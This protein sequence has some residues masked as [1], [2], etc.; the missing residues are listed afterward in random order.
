MKECKDEASPLGSM[1]VKMT[2]VSVQQHGLALGLTYSC[3]EVVSQ[4]GC[5]AAS[6]SVIHAGI[7][8]TGPSLMHCIWIWLSKLLLIIMHVIQVVGNACGSDGMTGSGVKLCVG[9][10]LEPKVKS[11]I[12]G[13]YCSLSVIAQSRIHTDLVRVTEVGWHF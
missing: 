7:L 8:G 12:L 10:S 2:H 11:L 1:Q 5:D 3:D 9:R 6:R 13:K 4:R